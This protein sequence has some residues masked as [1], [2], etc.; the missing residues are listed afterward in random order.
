MEQLW[1]CKRDP[2]NDRPYDCCV[3]ESDGKGK[4]DKEEI[5]EQYMLPKTKDSDSEYS[6][7]LCRVWPKLRQKIGR[8]NGIVFH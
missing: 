2:R 3:D 4:L 8:K 5:E 6:R 7:A 1:T